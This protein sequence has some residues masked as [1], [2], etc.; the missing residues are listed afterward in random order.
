M[1][2]CD[3]SVVGVT[4]ADGNAVGEVEACRRRGGGLCGWGRPMGGGGGR[5]VDDWCGGG[6]GDGSS[7]LGSDGARQILI[8]I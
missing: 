4:E 6:C 2:D 3:W 8:K 7:S 1:G 5:W